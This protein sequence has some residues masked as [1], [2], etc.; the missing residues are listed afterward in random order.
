MKNFLNFKVLAI[1][2]LMLLTSLANANT[3]YVERLDRGAIAIKESDGYH[4]SWRL[5]GDEPYTTGF[6]VYRG[7]TLLNSEPITDV[8]SY[9]DAN[10]SV[11]ALYY[12][13]AVINGVEI[14]NTKPARVLSSFEGSNAAYFDI[15][16]D[17]P[18]KGIHGGD[19][20]PNDASAG[21]LNG[22]GEYDIVL[23]WDPSN[24][25]DNSQSGTTDNVILDGYTLD[26]EHLWRIDLGQNIRAGAH[27]T[28]FLVYDFDGNGKAEIMCKTAP[29]TKD[30]SGNYI[31]KGPALSADHT[32]AYRNSSGRVLAGPEYLTVFDGETGLEL[33]TTSYWPLRGPS[34]SW[35]SSWGDSYG[36][37]MDRFNATVAYIDGERPTAVFQRGYYGRMTLAAWNWRDGQLT[38]VWTFDSDAGNRSYRGQGNHSIHAFDVDKDGHDEIITGAAVISEDGTG[39][40]TTG[41]GHGDACHISYSKKMMIVQWYLWRMSIHLSVFLYVMPMMVKLF[42]VKPEVRILAAL[43]LDS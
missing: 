39:L 13:K 32:I 36:N 21:D 23:K 38:K 11:S 3:K 5:L 30:A 15:P 43:V 7:T 8:T 18:A 6:N 14:E 31:S 40:Y 37:R 4:I 34:S 27:Y 17:R 16:L 41:A 24:S 29:G 12:V 19:Y 35:D 20:T 42:S 26:G 9:F 1:A 33:A 2:V 10:T 22:D 25:K 28:Q